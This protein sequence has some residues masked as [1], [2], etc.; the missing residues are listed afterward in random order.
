MGGV[1]EGAVCGSSTRASASKVL[2]QGRKQAA[3]AAV[4]L[5][6]ALGTMLSARTASGAGPGEDAGAVRAEDALAVNLNDLP[7]APDAELLMPGMEHGESDI[8]RVFQTGDKGRVWHGSWSSNRGFILV[9]PRLVSQE[10][11]GQTPGQKFAPEQKFTPRKDQMRGGFPP[12]WKGPGST[13]PYRYNWKGLLIQSVEFN[14]LENGFRMANDSLLRDITA[15]K[16]FWHDWIASLHQFNMHRWADGDDF[17][18]N[19]VGHP[20]QGAIAADLEIQNSPLDARV[21][22]GEPGYYRTRF[23]GLLWSLA[24]ST[25]SEL[26]PLGEAGLGSEGGF[27]Y[28]TKCLESCTPANFHPGD[29]YTNNTGWVDFIIT[30]AVGMLWNVAEDVLDK[31]VSNRIQG[32]DQKR[33]LPKAIRGALNPARSYANISRGR[34]PW[35]RDFQEPLPEPSR[36]N[37]VKSDEELARA[38]NAPRFQISP[39]FMGFPIATNT[40]ACTN[41]RRM[42][43]GA[44]VEI[45]RRLTRWLDT[46]VDVSYQPG[47]SPLPSDRAGGNMLTGFFGMRSGWETEHYS[48]KAALRPGF[49][50]FD[51]AYQSSLVSV[52]LPSHLPGIPDFGPSPDAGQPGGPGSIVVNPPP[53]VGNITHFAWNVNLTGDYK[54]TRSVALRAGIGENLVRYR[55]NKIDPP[56]IGEP[57]YLSWLSKEN[58]INRGNWSYQVG[59]VFSF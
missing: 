39:H 49:V 8:A 47:A 51:R 15:H 42:T 28:G 53:H 6:I 18:V 12:R 27:T 32:N 1:I 59:P 55:S 13:H 44:G 2:R 46:D 48:F 24:Y 9:Q 43:T 20:M 34:V 36:V 33:K 52:V 23:K 56:G 54:V 4:L 31:D 41:C 25:H 16:P 35:Y 22:W 17:L 3:R 14:F 11:P 37:F 45:S 50:R 10:L 38:A 7:S 21:Q 58:F 26:S 30:P 5:A 29:H 19:Y 57:P 40:V